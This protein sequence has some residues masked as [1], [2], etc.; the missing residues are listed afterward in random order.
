MK[1]KYKEV[2]DVGGIGFALRIELTQKDGITPNRELC[3]AMQ[4]LYEK[5]GYYREGLATLELKGVDGAAEIQKK[6]QTF[7]ELATGETFIYSINH[8]KAKSG[9]A[10]GADANKGDGQ[11][12]FNASRVAEANGVMANESGYIFDRGT[13]S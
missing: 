8:F 7:R 3:D 6:M 9:S 10:S 12:A 5:Y 11:G 1:S 13:S 2:G 4:D